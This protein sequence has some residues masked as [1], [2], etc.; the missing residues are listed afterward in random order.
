MNK[1]LTTNDLLAL[2]ARLLLADI[3]AQKATG[4]ATYT[5]IEVEKC[6]DADVYAWL[7]ANGKN[8]SILPE[9]RNIKK[10]Y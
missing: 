2:I 5:N 3:P 4:Q 9:N 1:T 8:S 7:R 6:M 10:G